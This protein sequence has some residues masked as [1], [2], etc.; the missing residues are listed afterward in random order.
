MKVGSR[1]LASLS[2]CAVATMLA[3]TFD[4]R[5]VSA[6]GGSPS[7]NLDQCA[8]GPASAPV[9]CTGAA[10]QNGN[11]NASS[12]HWAEGDSVA[13]RLKFGNLLPGLHQVTIQWDTTKSG[14]HALDYLTSYDRTVT[15]DP[16]S[17]VLGCIGV[18]SRY[19][20]P[21]DPNTG[22]NLPAPG[23]NPPAWPSGFPQSPIDG[24]WNQ[25]FTMFGGTITGLS[26]YNL[27]GTYAGDSSTSITI[28]FLA[29]TPNPVLAWGAHIA[30]RKDW[31][32]SNSAVSISGSPFHMR[33]L[34]LDGTGGQQD[35][36]LSSS[37]VI[38]PAILTITKSVLGSNGS[39]LFSAT[40]FTFTSISPLVNGFPEV[41]PSFT[42]VNDGVAPQPGELPANQ[43]QFNL[44]LFGATTPQ[45][46]I[47][48]Q[49]TAGFCLSGLACGAT[50]N[51]VPQTNKNTVNLAT[52]TATIVASEGEEIDCTYVNQQYATL[53]VIKKVVKTNGGTAEAGSFTLR[54]TGDGTNLSAPGS[55]SGTV[56][57]L[58]PGTYT[59][60]EDVP[61]LS[62]YRQT[63]FSG[64][65]NASGTVVLGLGGNK[66]C[67]VTN[68]D[69]PGH[70]I[71]RKVVDNTAGGTKRATD[72]SFSVNGGAPTPFKQDGTDV[73]K[74]LN[75]V[76]VS[77]GSFNVVEHATPIA[78]Y[79][80]TYSGCS[81]TILNDETRTCTITNTAQ[82]AHLI[83]NKVVVN[84][85]GGSLTA[86][87]F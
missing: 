13:Y 54:V 34:G 8:N 17:G 14:K 46:A 63:G 45:V 15:G 40:P 44:Y 69:L 32:S 25:F 83:I 81:G 28:T 57:S 16:C 38:F 76:D 23:T 47:T 65:C 66:T 43:K 41:D 7:A 59:V 53:T 19:L 56:Y 12:A 24:R 37:A 86:A 72:F 4:T 9:T 84:N 20:I 64:D 51:G 21:P 36:G 75:T 26:A 52:G 78:G 70:L 73:L 79:S 1:L 58:R 62:G 61:T 60:S 3:A 87:A 27:A 11:A 31:G 77:A 49:P 2:F 74:G 68:N 10:W 30:T 50:L 67:T 42:L 85:N 55:A 5:N 71:V 22:L 82:T 80:T 29:A 48:E 33:V 39:P 35:R 6:A 18:G